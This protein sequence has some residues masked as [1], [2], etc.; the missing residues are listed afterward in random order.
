MVSQTSGEGPRILTSLQESLGR[1][2]IKLKNKRYN[3]PAVYTDSLQLTSKAA[4]HQIG[5]AAWCP[6]WPGNGARSFM[7][8]LLDGRKI[9]PQ[10]NN[11]YGSYNN[12]KTNQLIDQALTA[13][14]K[15]AAGGGLGRGRQA[16]DD[17]R[18]LGAAHL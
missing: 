11:N 2:G 14:D 15:D 5:Q 9:T 8:A 6:D 12:D 10:G 1:A 4:E 18:G 13:A 3:Y 7:G 17:R 16:G